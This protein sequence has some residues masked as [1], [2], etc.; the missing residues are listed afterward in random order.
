MP[1]A[2]GAWPHALVSTEA[3]AYI[4]DPTRSGAAAERLIGVNYAGAMI[5][6]GR[7]LDDNFDQARHQ[8]WVGQLRRCQEMI[9]STTGGAVRVRRP[10]RE[11]L[12][13]S[14]SQI[15]EH[16]LGGWRGRVAN[17]LGLT[18]FPPKTNAANER[19]VQHLWNHRDRLLTFFC[20]CQVWTLPTGVRNW[21]SGS[22]SSR[23]R[24][25]VA[26]GPGRACGRSRS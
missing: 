18:I 14:G 24:S 5:R 23:A 25:G 11:L 16:G 15:G 3:T 19:L 22:D 26:S 6:G 10:I 8:P 12:Q 4:I 7:S 21:R 13:L 20:M 1:A 2:L 9:P 17:A